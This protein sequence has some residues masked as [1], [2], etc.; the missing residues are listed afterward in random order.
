MYW[1][2]QTGSNIGTNN[3]NYKMF[4]CETDEDVKKLP[5][6]T[7]YGQ[8]GDVNS[9]DNKPC[10]IGCECAVVSTGKR[11]ILDSNSNKWIENK[12]NLNP[13][14]GSGG[15]GGGGGDPEDAEPA[16]QEDID[17]VIDDLDDL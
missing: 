2:Y 7:S 16:T 12:A 1:V 11:Y 5:T 4:V 10:I 13:G 14:G 6:T 15:S 8:Q 9:P 17:E 3:P